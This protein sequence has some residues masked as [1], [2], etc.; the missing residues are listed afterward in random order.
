M[1]NGFASQLTMGASGAALGT[2]ISRV[3]EFSVICGYLVFK[4]KE[5]AYKSILKAEVKLTNG[6]KMTV[7]DYSS[8]GKLWRE[9]SKM[10]VWMLTV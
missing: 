1:V 2:L 4:D 8:A 9:E 5:I 3:F 6:E 7:T 10:A